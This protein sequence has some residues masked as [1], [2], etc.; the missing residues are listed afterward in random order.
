MVDSQGLTEAGREGK[1]L[2]CV[3][4]NGEYLDHD[5]VQE[6]AAW[7][8]QRRVSGQ[9]LYHSPSTDTR[10]GTV[11]SFTQHPADLNTT[12]RARVLRRKEEERRRRLHM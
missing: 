9:S 2:D 11:G 8:D 12:N 4:V 1:V 6:T 7:R 10:G 3:L 5:S